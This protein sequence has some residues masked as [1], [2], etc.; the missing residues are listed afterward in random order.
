MAD[1]LAEGADVDA[2]LG[3]WD[4]IGMA[5]DNILVDKD[6]KPWRID[7]GGSLSFRAQGGKKKGWTEG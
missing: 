2:M 7:N 5:A 6:G 4:V 3:N 1:S